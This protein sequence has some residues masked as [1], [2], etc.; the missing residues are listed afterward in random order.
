[1]QKTRF[2]K[3]INAIVQYCLMYTIS[4][5]EDVLFDVYFWIGI[6]YSCK[7]CFHELQ[8]EGEIQ[9]RHEPLRIVDS[10][11]SGPGLYQPKP[12]LLRLALPHIRQCIHQLLHILCTCYDVYIYTLVVHLYCLNNDRSNGFHYTVVV[13]CETGRTHGDW[14]PSIE[15][16]I[17]G[18]RWEKSKGWR[19]HSDTTLA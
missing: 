15:L 11:G 7:T 18:I 9:S 19:I 6:I 13:L 1:M 17:D 3:K 16:C 12:G 14:T 10:G 8:D 5:Y 2:I 4:Y